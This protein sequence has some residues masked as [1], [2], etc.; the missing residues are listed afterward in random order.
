MTVT[1]DTTTPT[2]LSTLVEALKRELAVPGTFAT[3]FPDTQDTDLSGSLADAFAQA[4]LDGFFSTSMVDLSTPATPQVSPPL[5]SGG[6]ALVIL[7]AAERTIRAQLRVLNTM[8][9]YEAAGVSYETQQAAS[10]LVQELKD[11][12]ARRTNLLALLL[13]QQRSGQAVHVTDGYL[14]RGRGYYPAGFYGEF[15][16]FYGYEMLGFTALSSW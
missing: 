16:F 8:V 15:G 12:Q 9:K 13:R 3:V 11:I 14:I 1:P 10:V 2:D 5:S 7:Y 4:Q 6:G